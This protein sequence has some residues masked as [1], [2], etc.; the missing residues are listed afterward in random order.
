MA[1]EII[2]KD[3]LSDDF[4]RLAKELKLHGEMTIVLTNGKVMRAKIEQVMVVRDSADKSMIYEVH[5]FKGS[6]ERRY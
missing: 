4:Q 2:V 1:N 3:I 6:D 5:L